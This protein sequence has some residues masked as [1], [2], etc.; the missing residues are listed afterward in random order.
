MIEYWELFGV[1]KALQKVE[2]LF[3]KD[4]AQFWH[5]CFKR[6]QLIPGANHIFKR[7]ASSE[8]IEQLQDYL[9]EIRYALLFVG[10][11]FQV[12]I[13]PLGPKGPDLKII[14]DGHPILVE[15]T[16]FRKIYPGPPV[17]DLSDENTILPTYGNP[18]R[19]IRKAF[20]KILKKFPQVGDDEAIIAIWNDDEDMEE[21][22]VNTAVIDLRNDAAQERI[23][24]PIG[25]LF[26][27]YGS[28]WV[29]GVGNRQL[30]CFP[31]QY[32]HQSHHI[33]LQKELDTSQVGILIQ[34]ALDDSK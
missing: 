29:G 17:L 34:Q 12:E 19:D 28:K 24:L 30:Y 25:L 6:L 27:L 3:D 8:D 4:V 2:Q 10:L 5:P 13:E 14:R 7:I 1:D 20:E 26:V 31:L 22:E 32:L 18:P 21:V 33:T 11:R 16:R 23:N 15:I 9:T